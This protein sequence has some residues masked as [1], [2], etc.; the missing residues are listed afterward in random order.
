MANETTSLGVEFPKQQK[1]CRELLERYQKLGPA[2]AFAAAMIKR[3]LEE[4][5]QA[6]ISGEVPRMIAAYDELL[7][8]K[9]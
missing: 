7:G 6:A 5:E 3:A 8:F 9:S 2:G 1:R 4:A